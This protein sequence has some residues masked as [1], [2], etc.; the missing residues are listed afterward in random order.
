MLDEQ[1]M[2]VGRRTAR[3]RIAHSVLTLHDKASRRGLAD[4]RG[5]VALPIRQRQLA[6]ALGLSVVH[7]NK[8]LRHLTEAGH[9][10]WHR[11]RLEVR[12][13]AALAHI[14]SYARHEDQ[15]L[16]LI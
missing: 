10:R 12:D 8:T 2:S 11:G 13:R 1:L 14:A 6:D 15:L 7:T 9:M 5:V 3:E 16:P 4:A